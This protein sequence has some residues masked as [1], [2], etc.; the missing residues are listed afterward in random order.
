MGLDQY[1]KL[2]GLPDA[3]DVRARL[4]PA[5]LALLPVVAIVIGVHHA[6]MKLNVAVLSL[7]GFLGVFYFLA[8]L[9]R[10]MGKRQED[11]LF[12]K[13]GGKPST[14]LLRHAD[15]FLDS[16]TKGRYHR[17]LER[18]ID[19][20]FPTDGQERAAP[21]QADD[22]YQA[23]VRWLLGKTR[24]KTKFA[25]LFNE[26]VSYGFRRNCYGI[27]WIAI[28]ISMFS[29][30]WILI[31]RGVVTH[32]GLHAENLLYLGIG[33]TVAMLIS[34]VSIPVWILFFTEETVKTSSISYAD[35]LLRSCDNLPKKR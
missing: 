19:A 4:T 23:A 29:I 25:M 11:R 2:T 33:A 27:R 18:W 22:V 16:T 17:F 28:C 10:E 9:C 8:T 3:Y 13:W 30:L 34:V 21:E 26:N 14:R 24:D 35:F 7:F 32:T 6:E 5:F 1:S 20:P 31:A 15:T 12:K